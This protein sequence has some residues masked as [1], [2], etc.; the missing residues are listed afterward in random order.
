MKYNKPE[1]VV[2][3][4]ASQLIQGSKTVPADPQGLIASADAEMDD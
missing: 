3:G 1:V 4:D 2:L